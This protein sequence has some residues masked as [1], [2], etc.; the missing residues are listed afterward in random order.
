MAT[1]GDYSDYTCEQPLCTFSTTGVCVKNF[2]PANKCPFL[3]NEHDLEDEDLEDDVEDGDEESAL[4]NAHDIDDLKGGS[5]GDDED[6]STPVADSIYFAS[7]EALLGS[8]I[9]TITYAFP[10]KLILIIGGPDCGKTTL[11]S[12]VFE[13]F[14]KRAL[15]NFIFAGSYTQVGF[16]LISYLAREA[17][18]KIDPDTERT[19]SAEFLYLHLSIRDKLLAH[20]AQHLLFTDVSGE[21]FNLARDTQAEMDELTIL[22]KADHIFYIVD[23]EALSN[24]KTRDTTKQDVIIFLKRAIKANLLTKDNQLII[25]INKFDR[26]IKNSAQQAVELFFTA[27]LKKLFPDI[28]ADIITTVARPKR[29]SL[30]HQTHNLD[31]FLDLCTRNT[32]IDKENLVYYTSTTTNSREF[33]RLFSK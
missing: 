3:S 30:S 15:G 7:G 23:G 20:K 6:K 27:Q 28:I 12:A 13:S 2:T 4:L 19:K 22:K 29:D 14:Q 24:V 17:S 11:V 26:V 8:S 21:R 32:K 16:E 1:L 10:A 5:P 33:S 25:L 18:G 31:V 9:E